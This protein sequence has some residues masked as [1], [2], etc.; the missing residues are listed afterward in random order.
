MDNSEKLQGLGSMVFGMIENVM[1]M[2]ADVVSYTSRK[3]SFPTKADRSERGEVMVMVV[4]DKQLF[5]FIEAAI[6]NGFETTDIETPKEWNQ[7]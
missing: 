2:P 7:S 1:L 6:R 5:E 4:R 3:V